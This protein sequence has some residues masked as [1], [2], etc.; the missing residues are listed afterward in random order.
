[1][2]SF[3]VVETLPHRQRAIVNLDSIALVRIAVEQDGGKVTKL[4]MVDGFE[5]SVTT[6]FEVLQ[7]KLNAITV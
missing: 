3:L 2:S 1:M 7:Q 4:R 6:D 5:L